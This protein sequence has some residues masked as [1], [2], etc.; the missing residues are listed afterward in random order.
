VGVATGALAA[1][2]GVAVLIGWHTGNGRLTQLYPGFTPMAYNTSVSFGALGCALVAL[3]LRWSRC[4]QLAAAVAGILCLA[5]LVEYVNGAPRG[6]D[7]LF[8]RVGL[9]EGLLYARP[10][11][12]NTAICFV[13]LAAAV[14]L[15]S[16]P[17]GFRWRPEVS[18]LFGSAGVDFGL[19]ALAGYL[20]AFH[21]F[22]WGNFPPMAIHTSVGAILLG[23]GVLTL[24][25]R[26]QN[27]SD[28]NR[29]SWLPAFLTE[30]GIV[31]SVSLWQALVYTE[32]AHVEL[33]IRSRSPMP[34]T[35]LAAGLLVT[36]L[37]GMAVYL[38][39]MAW[40][41]T[42]VAERMRAEVEI[43]AAN[44][45]R[46]DERYRTL[47]AAT[48]EELHRLN[49]GLERLVAERTAELRA[50]NRGLEAFA[51]S[52]SHD[53]RAPLRHMDGFLGLLERRI[54]PD[55]DPTTRHLVQHAVN[56]AGTMATLI[57]AL[58]DFSRLGRG[59]MRQIEVDME[60]LAQSVVR[61]MEGEVTRRQVEW[62]IDLCR[63][64]GDPFLLRLVLQNLVSN[65][66]KFTRSRATAVIEIGQA[67]ADGRET[68]FF[69]R[70]NGVG[71]DMQYVGK[72]FGVFQ[73]LHSQQDF[74]GTGIGLANVQ[75]IV[76]RHGGR[77]W[78]HGAVDQGATIYFALPIC[79]NA[80]RP[81]CSPATR[82]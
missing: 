66:V 79:V 69:V 73:R 11:A 38:A 17:P 25:W 67:E 12:P 2:L 80:E 71:F 77:V 30:G 78:A 1:A 35:V 33:A 42:R 6:I 47:V 45:Q 4:A 54:G 41:R 63:A 46:S 51:Y 65:A 21:T 57:D 31:T 28:R 26:D 16:G 68:V 59:E 23:A 40:L 44:R 20:M 62:K 76:Q 37:L 53:L 5:R 8:A 48:S 64:R 13:L 39:Q 75:R 43:E 56:A 32:R 70:D 24:S 27:P 36:A 72:L 50:V 22:A 52:V 18:A 58:L 61:D 82:Y 49:E 14:L 74:E 9:A 7:G 55:A 3:S 15:L 60:A 19:N 10:M 34:E 81:S 29:H